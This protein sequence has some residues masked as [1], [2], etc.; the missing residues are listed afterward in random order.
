M[1]QKELRKMFRDIDT[2]TSRALENIHQVKRQRSTKVIPAP[3]PLSSRTFEWTYVFAL[4]LMFAL[5]I[6]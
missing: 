1:A 6:D 5:V 3:L 2:H 4:L